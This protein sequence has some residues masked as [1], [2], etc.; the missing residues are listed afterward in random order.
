[1]AVIEKIAEAYALLVQKGRRDI[2]S[3]PAEYAEAVSEI[4][5]N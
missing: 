2:E 4:L 3:I 1:M 5:Q